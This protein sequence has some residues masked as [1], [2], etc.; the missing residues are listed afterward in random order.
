MLE[1]SGYVSFIQCTSLTDHFYR[2]ME[3]REFCDMLTD[4]GELQVL[5]RRIHS[6]LQ[7][8]AE[9][10]LCGV[11]RNVPPTPVRVRGSVKHPNDPHRE[12]DIEICPF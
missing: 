9:D 1:G 6:D 12:A 3:A 8:S 2:E 4:D 5:N 7:Q 10:F 11:S